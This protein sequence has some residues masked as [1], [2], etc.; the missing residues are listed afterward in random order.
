MYQKIVGEHNEREL[1][2]TR[3]LYRFNGKDSRQNQKPGI[4]EQFAGK[5]AGFYEEQKNAICEIN[6]FYA[7]YS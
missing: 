3:W 5:T 6:D 7:Q 4:P 1:K 2:Q